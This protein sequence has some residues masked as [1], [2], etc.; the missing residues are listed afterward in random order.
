[1]CG[2]SG[3]YSLK[4]DKDSNQRQTIARAMEKAIAHRGPDRAEFW[5]DPESPLTLIHR[6]LSI[7]DL[8]E[9]G[10]QPKHSNSGRYVIVT[11][12]EIYNYLELQAELEAAGHEF[13][14][15]SDTEVMLTAFEHWGVNQAIQKLNGMFAF[16]LWD[17]KEKQLHFVRGPFW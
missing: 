9:G 1:M 3:F 16:V 12:G 8:S 11:N 6:R 17:K 5:L 7:I 15:R 2:I 4:A 14:T 10:A 13:K